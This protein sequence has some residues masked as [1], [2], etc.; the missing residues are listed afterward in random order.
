[1]SVA[2]RLHC[3]EIVKEL[4]YLFSRRNET[5]KDATFL[6]WG[7]ADPVAY[8]DYIRH[9]SSL[10]PPVAVSF[11]ASARL[12]DRSSDKMSGRGGIKWFYFG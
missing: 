6:G 3:S 2:D 12:P 4:S 8:D 10:S 7:P 5:V 1:M 11:D 9:L